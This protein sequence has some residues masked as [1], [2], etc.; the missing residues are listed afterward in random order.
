MLPIKSIDVLDQVKQI[1]VVVRVTIVEFFVTIIYIANL[2]DRSG[3][4]QAIHKREKST[5][6]QDLHLFG[7]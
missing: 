5:P 4:F 1:T 6:V 7:H 2:V 3:T